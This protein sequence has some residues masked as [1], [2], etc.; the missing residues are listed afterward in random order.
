MV[1]FLELKIKVFLQQ[2]N[3]RLIENKMTVEHE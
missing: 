3:N 2:Y 1:A